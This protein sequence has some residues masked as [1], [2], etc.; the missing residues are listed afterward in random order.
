MQEIAVKASANYQHGKVRADKYFRMNA[1]NDN[2]PLFLEGSFRLH[3]SRN[4][5]P[6]PR[7]TLLCQNASPTP[8]PNVWPCVP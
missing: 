1:R 5:T 2:T 7:S 4:E 8:M 6:V 3:S